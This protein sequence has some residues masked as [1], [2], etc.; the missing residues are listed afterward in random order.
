MGLTSQQYEEE[1]VDELFTNLYIFGQMQEK[2]RI[3]LEHGNQ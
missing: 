1:P 2:Q 3:D